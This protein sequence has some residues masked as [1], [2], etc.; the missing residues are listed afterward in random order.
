M[1]S[2]QSSD[3]YA[4]RFPIQGPS[5]QQSRRLR[6]QGLEPLKI[7]VT[8]G[9]PAMVRNLKTTTSTSKRLNPAPADQRET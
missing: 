2:K 1:D 4:K 9:D 8:D 3:D 7:D 5:E 6:A